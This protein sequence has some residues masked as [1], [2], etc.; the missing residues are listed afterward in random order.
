LQNAVTEDQ[1]QRAR[2][3]FELISRQAG[4]QFREVDPNEDGSVSADISIVTG[5]MRAISPL[6]NSRPNIDGNPVVP[7]SQLGNPL[8]TL[9]NH[10]FVIM[11]AG[12]NW[13][14]SAYGGNWFINAMQGITRSTGVVQHLD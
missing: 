6:G 2:E 9:L 13:G 5:D 1:K 7:T 12:V 14:I 4:I 10:H 3:I 8:N 11:D